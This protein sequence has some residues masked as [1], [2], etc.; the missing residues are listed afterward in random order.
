[1]TNYLFP[2]KINPRKT[3]F[4]NLPRDFSLRIKSCKILQAYIREIRMNKILH[5]V[6]S[7]SLNKTIII[8]KIVIIPLYLLLTS[9]KVISF[10]NL[11]KVGEFFQKVI[12]HN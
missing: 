10:P 9:H 2:L 4:H 7:T 12:N 11:I 1:M 5:R 3:Q 6:L 8:I